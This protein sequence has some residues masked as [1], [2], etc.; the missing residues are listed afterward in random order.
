MKVFR[1]LEYDNRD[2][3]AAQNALQQYWGTG[4]FHTGAAEA[5]EACR[6]LDTRE[7]A[8][9]KAWVPAGSGLTEARCTRAREIVEAV[10]KEKSA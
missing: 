8:L 1:K 4:G 9:L 10:L 6:K 3:R 2:F 7:L 5:A